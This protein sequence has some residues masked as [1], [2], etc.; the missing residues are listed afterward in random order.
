MQAKLPNPLKKG[1][2]EN[3]KRERKREKNLQGTLDF[4]VDLRSEGNIRSADVWAL[5]CRR[6]HSGEV[7][8]VRPLALGPHLNGKTLK[9]ELYSDFSAK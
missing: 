7:E 2:R 8:P 3:E 1:G 4:R 6:P 9:T 5:R